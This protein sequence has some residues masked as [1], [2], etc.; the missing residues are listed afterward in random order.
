MSGGRE[1]AEPGSPEAERSHQ[2]LPLLWVKG[3]HLGRLGGAAPK[4]RCL[5]PRFDNHSHSESWSAEDRALRSLHLHKKMMFSP[6][7][8]FLVFFIFAPKDVSL[9]AVS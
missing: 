7:H 8:T 4:R 1:A 6:S 2:L 9:N 3:C 5:F